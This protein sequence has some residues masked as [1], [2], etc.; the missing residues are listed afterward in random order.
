MARK[1]NNYK[2]S[3]NK[4][5]TQR[6]NYQDKAEEAEFLKGERAATNKLNRNKNKKRNKMSGEDSGSWK[7][8]PEFYNPGTNLFKSVTQVTF[9]ASNGLPLI[10]NDNARN[11]NNYLTGMPAPLG[12]SSSRNWGAKNVA[13]PGI[14]TL[15]LVP[16]IGQCDKVSDPINVAINQQYAYINQNKSGALPYDA[17]DLG[18]FNLS[19]ANVL[20]FIK[21]C[22]R[23]YG[24]TRRYRA[25]DRYTPQALITANKV[26]FED[27][28]KNASNFRVWLNQYILRARSFAV[29]K[30][31]NYFK[32]MDMLFDA[33][34]FDSENAKAQYYM[35]T[36]AGFYI[37]QE[38]TS[39]AIVPKLTYTPLTTTEPS[40]VPLTVAQL[41]AYGE[42]MLQPIEGSQDMR[43]IQADMLYVFKAEGCW[44]IPEIA[45]DYEVATVYDRAILSQIENAYIYGASGKITGSITQSAAINDSCL[46]NDIAIESTFAQEDTQSAQSGQ[47]TYFNPFNFVQPQ[48]LVLNFHWDNPSNEDIMEATRLSG[49][50]LTPYTRAGDDEVT[51]FQPITCGTEFVAGAFIWFYQYD[52]KDGTEYADISLVQTPFKTLFFNLIW[53]ASSNTDAIMRNVYRYI[54]VFAQIS[55]FDWHPA[56]YPVPYARFNSTMS[57]VTNVTALEVGDV[58]LDIDN[59]ALVN[60]HQLKQM[61]SIAL[62]GEFIVRSMGAYTKQIMD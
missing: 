11:A 14:M 30:D 28:K 33:I 56:I 60:A 61:N 43:R 46:I 19:M 20:A 2:N 7:N 38:G 47:G 58:H 34:Y 12:S 17:P 23:L 62:L 51:L 16:T 18:F 41:Q 24:I 44:T 3:S 8:D 36:P 54:N 5:N 4:S 1:R 59:F 9:E 25:I 39:A 29:P 52:N 57:G 40:V 27:L 45:E 31:I 10:V 15:D 6:K 48:N 13:S 55:K 50:G 53:P 49:I 22:K 42:S 37:Y 26:D 32:R 21:F 35:F